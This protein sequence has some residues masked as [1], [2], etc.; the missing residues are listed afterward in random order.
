MKDSEGCIARMPATQQ[1]GN[2]RLTPAPIGPPFRLKVNMG[3]FIK[4]YRREPFPEFLRRSQAV[5]QHHFNDHSICGKW[6]NFSIELEPEKRMEITMET[7][8]KFRDKMKQPGLY[9]VVERLTTHLLSPER[10][11]ESHHPCDSQKNEAMNQSATKHA[12]KGRVCSKSASLRSRVAVCAGINSVGKFE[13]VSRLF[14]CLGVVVTKVT[15]TQ[16]KVCDERTKKKKAHQRLPSTKRTRASVKK[17]KL[18]TLLSAEIKSKK[19]HEDC[20]NGMAVLNPLSVSGAVTTTPKKRQKVQTEGGPRRCGA[21]GE[22]GHR[23]D[24]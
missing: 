21:C 2:S 12:P 10:P 11:R 22:V 15:E 6:C 23:R 8:T 16:L 14:Q 9:E 13:C 17:Q 1:A 19:Q 20:E 5:I 18:A 7:A 24:S 3:Y 4:M